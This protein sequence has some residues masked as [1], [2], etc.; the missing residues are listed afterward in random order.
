MLFIQLHELCRAH[1]ISSILCCKRCGFSLPKKGPIIHP[2]K[3]PN[4]H[5]IGATPKKIEREL[6]GLFRMYETLRAPV[7]TCTCFPDINIFIFLGDD[8]FFAG[9]L[10]TPC[11]LRD[12]FTLL[13]RFSSWTRWICWHWV[14]SNSR[15]KWANEICPRIEMHKYTHI[16]TLVARVVH[17]HASHVFRGNEIHDR[18]M[19]LWSS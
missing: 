6:Y 1:W 8:F 14:E 3:R 10:S 13:W 5:R 15:R 18:C 17:I 2:E 11:G 7:T 4:T 12:D 9:L 16:H 19:H